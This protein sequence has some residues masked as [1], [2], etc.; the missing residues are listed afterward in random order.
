MTIL[1]ANLADRRVTADIVG[2][3]LIRYTVMS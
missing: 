3:V 1:L 2:Q